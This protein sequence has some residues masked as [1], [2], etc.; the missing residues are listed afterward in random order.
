MAR[1]TLSP[2]ERQVTRVHRRLLLQ[3]LL[4]SVIWCWAGAILLSAGW[5]LVQPFVIQHPP[6]WLR[7]VVAGGLVGASSVLAV[8]L[9]V[10]QAPSKLTAA[11]SMDSQF[12]LKERVTT[13]L[14]LPAE[15]ITSP[16]G[17]ALLADVESAHR[18][19]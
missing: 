16:A 4:N 17:Q 13:S 7:W 3:M 19:S 12:G 14:T 2:V 18:G 9:L 5:F 6:V 1:K 11:L 8:V 10:P 15:Q